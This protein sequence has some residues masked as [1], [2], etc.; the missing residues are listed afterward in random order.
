MSNHKKLFFFNKEGD[1]LNFKYNESTDRFEGDIL[2]HKNSTDTYK[3]AAIYTLENIPS[4]EYEIPGE[5]S[6]KKFQLFNEKGFHFYGTGYKAED[7]VTKMEPVNNDPNFYTKWIYG[8]NFDRK[9]PVGSLIKFNTPFLEFNNPNQAFTVISTGPSKIMIVSFIDNA[10]F[11]AQYQPQYVEVDSYLDVTISGVN[12]FGVYD[13]RDANYMPKLSLWNEREFFDEYYVGR[14]INVIGSEHNDGIITVTNSTFNDLTHFEYSLDRTSLPQGT[15]LVMEVLTRTDVPLVYQGGMTLTGN[16]IEIKELLRYPQTLKPGIEFKIV[17]SQSSATNF[18]RVASIRDFRNITTTTA[19]NV[20]DQVIWNGKIYQ[21]IT[22]YTQSISNLA[23][24]NITPENTDYWSNPTYVGVENSFA[25]EDLLSAQIFLTSDRYYYTYGWTYSAETTLASFAQKY[26][27]NLEIFNI[28]LYYANKKLK[29]DLKYPSK[30]AIVNF[31]H[32]NIGPT[33]SIG[34]VNE[35]VERIVEV[36]EKLNTE[37]N[38][39]YSENQKYVVVF[40]DI[41][42]FGIKLVIN[43]QIYDEEAVLI[44]SGAY[45]DMERTIDKTL[46]NWLKRWYVD[47]MALGVLV[48]LKYTGSF[49][50]VFYN[51]IVIKSEYPNVEVQLND[52][53]VGT[54]AFYYLEHS[55]VLF[56]N[57]GTYLNINIDG[58]D[59]GFTVSTV[60]ATLSI[61]TALADWE[62]RYSSTVA[63]LH[64][65]QVKAYN[66]LLKF[67]LL[68]PGPRLSAAGL[69]LDYTITTG[70]TTLPGLP[71]YTIQT[72]LSGNPGVLVASNEI[73]LPSSS[74]F[75]FEN[76]GFSTGMALTINN[77]FYTYVNQDFVIQYLEPHTMNLS[78]QGP[79]WGLTANPCL[80]SPYQ[81]TGFDSGFSQSVCIVPITPTS[82]VMGPYYPPMFDPSFSIYISTFNVYTTNYYQGYPGLVDIEYVELTNSIFGFGDYLVSIDAYFGTLNATISLPGNTQSIE[83][84]LNTTN[85]YL[86]CLS[87]KKLYVVDPTSNTLITTITFSSVSYDA[88]DMEINPVN[89][90]VYVSYQNAARVDIWEFDNLTS[91]PS[92][93]LNTSTSNFPPLATRTGAMV[94]NEFE[95]DMYITT[96]GNPSGLNEVIRVNGGVVQN[97]LTN[98]N[99]TIQNTSY[100]IPGLTHSIFY[101]PVYE[102]IYVYGSASLWKIDNDAYEQIS[103]IV[104]R[105]FVD[106][107]FNNHYTQLNISDSNS[108]YTILNLGTTSYTTL[109]Y[110]NKYGYLGVSQFDNDVYMS[111]QSPG[112]TKIVIISSETG[113]IKD[114]LTLSSQTGRIIYNPERKSMWTYQASS[115]TFVEIEVEINQIITQVASTF[116]QIAENNYGTLDANYQPKES[117]WLKTRDYFRRPRENFESEIAVK[118]YWKWLTDQTPEFFM[119]D[120]SGEQLESTGP[121]AYTGEKPLSTIYLNKNPNRDLNRTHLPEEQ[122]T[123][124]NKIEYTLSYIDDSDDVSVEAQSL[125]LFLGFRSEQE[126]AIRSVLQL[127]KKEEISFDIISSSV[128]N[129]TFETL[130]PEGDKRG[131][132]MIN[133]TSTENFTGRGLKAGQHLTIYI[134]DNTNQFNQ[135]ISENN[136]LF[137]KIREVYSKQLIVD[138][139]SPAFDSLA[140]ENTKLVDYPKVTKTTYLKS[141]FTVR[142]REI[143]RFITYGETEDE[144][145][146]FKIELGNVGK[147]INPDEVFIFKEYDINEGGIDWTYLNMKRKEMLMTKDVIYPYI[148]A[149]KSIINAINYFGYNDLQLNE[150]YEQVE[151]LQDRSLT[152]S[153]GGRVLS[154]GRT[155]FTNRGRQLFKIEIPDI[156]DN[157]VKGWTE[158]DYITSEYLTSDKFRATNSFNLTYFITDKEGNYI[159]NYSLE[160][161]IIKLQGLKYWLKK[162][163]IPLTHKILDITGNA[164]VETGNHLTHNMYDCQMFKLK[165]QMTPVT[166]KMN[167]VYLSPVNSGS[168]VYNCVIEFYSI[169]ENLGANYN[170][171]QILDGNGELLDKPKPYYEFSNKLVSPD[172]FD[173]KIRT[174][175]TYKEWAPY[176]TYD[177]GD[178]VIYFDKLYESTKTNNKLNNPRKYENVLTW[179]PSSKYKVSD[180]VEYQREFYVFSGL[181][182]QSTTAPSFYPQSWLRITEW[183]LLDYEPVQIISEQ[184]KGT[185]LLPFNFTVD[186]NIDP[187]I[188]IEVTSHSGYGAVFAD[189]K[190]YYLKG[191]KD[192]TE[193]Y[194]PIDKLGPFTPITPVY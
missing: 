127:Y 89:G 76:A 167:E 21:C 87:K 136:G 145:I 163:I 155:I 153:T 2:F 29:A 86:Y 99:Q 150:Y 7:P 183:K 52:I 64:S 100:D 41:D 156:F 40:T 83:M 126:G 164:Y 71:D 117:V 26:K 15:N 109:G 186:S 178:K 96:E 107:I 25:Y 129:V 58:E 139:F 50:S 44:Y 180:V 158:K 45:I 92:V 17:A 54:T 47:L 57:M 168:T 191:T 118:Y 166:F 111:V 122:Q 65:V 90:D 93:T 106:M 101:D 97:F 67:D 27:S 84:E 73:I 85:S 188:T 12:A 77:T 51:S 43:N 123:V 75:S 194:R 94:F 79:F 108:D 124:F 160:E 37:L 23:T 35:T 16:R 177:V 28:D 48:E 88:F 116:S 22:S 30:Y 114:E 62:D 69:N 179:Q 60:G 8:D 81:V 70:R 184:R 131:R 5:L 72:N 159:L 148:G 61:S 112:I 133:E 125:E 78:Y 4:F 143:G 137:V 162:N 181:G 149:Y 115:N 119:Y 102:A 151:G 152:V 33:Y 3:T 80:V 147:L 56:S 134:K 154:S 110:T 104:T 13:Y 18:Y 165:E 38:Y 190:N 24:S 105:P 135:Y 31:Y 192:I 1:Y 14:K 11:E 140:T 187:F 98:P 132:I 95:G 174:Y 130:D 189:N 49:T 169:I 82:S 172:I 19:F 53:Q 176:V 182:G 113:Q 171:N 66:T 103:G 55:K 63:E 34:T 6:T 170:P 138:F 120:F 128:T 9:Y 144:D 32:T 121:Y 142:D 39:N 36:T 59:Y 42:E 68:D 185:N 74:T 161:I 146:R 173:I 193:P 157:T 141:T 175:K 10:T 91:S 46:R 20:E